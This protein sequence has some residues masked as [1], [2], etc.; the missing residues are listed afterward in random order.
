MR[1]GIGCDITPGDTGIRRCCCIIGVCGDLGGVM[2][3][4]TTTVAFGVDE[5]DS[6]SFLR[7][8]GEGGGRIT[9]SL[10]S[11]FFSSSSF[12]SSTGV[13]VRFVFVLCFGVDTIDSNI[14]SILCPSTDR[15]RSLVC[16]G[17]DVVVLRFSISS[18]NITKPLLRNPLLL[19]LDLGDR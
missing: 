17:D 16:V 3:S 19:L 18:S 14:S 11:N 4:C 1:G 7:L 13:I 6:F 10:F 5:R 12:N 8:G 9:S 2:S 15:D